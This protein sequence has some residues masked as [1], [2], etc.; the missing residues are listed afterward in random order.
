MEAIANFFRTESGASGVE[1]SM[2]LAFIAL[3]ALGSIGLLGQTVLTTL[4]EKVVEKFP[5]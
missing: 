1:Y 2:L 5:K 3:V 4:Y